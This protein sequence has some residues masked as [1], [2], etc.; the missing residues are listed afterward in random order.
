MLLLYKRVDASS[1][2]ESRREAPLLSFKPYKIENVFNW[3]KLGLRSK[4]NNKP[5]TTVASWTSRLPAEEP[6]LVRSIP[7][8]RRILECASL[9]FS[10]HRW[11]GWLTIRKLLVRAMLR[12]VGQRPK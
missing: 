5:L 10:L 1:D 7:S 6:K 4:K 2:D 12:S 9:V 3:V 11:C 8:R